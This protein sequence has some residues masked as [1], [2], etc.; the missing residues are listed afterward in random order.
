MI[1]FSAGFGILL[2]FWKIKKASKVIVIEKFP[3]FRLEDKETY[4]E[5]ATREYDRIAV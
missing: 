1:L 5:S 2:D 3:Y 4:A